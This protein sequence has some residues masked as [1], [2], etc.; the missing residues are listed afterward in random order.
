MKTR[1][2]HLNGKYDFES[3]ADLCELF[4]TPEDENPKYLFENGWLPT[5]NGEWYQSR[6]S[7]IKISPI[8]SRRKYQ[9]RKI[10][11]CKSGDYREIFEKSKY[12][13][14]PI[15]EEYLDTVLSFEHE[16]YYFNDNIFSILNWFGDI[17]YYSLV[18]GGKGSN[19]GITPLTCYYFIEQLV[20][21]SYPYLY[22]GEW[23][24]EFNYKTHYPNFEWWDGQNWNFG[25]T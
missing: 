24:D 1:I 6:S 18:L 4:C 5:S 16:I 12:I 22:I 17:P 13:Y 3:S 21:I 23:Y 14:D 7:R 9:L 8:S 20:G 25:N 2:S 10:R 15:V 19:N 11:T